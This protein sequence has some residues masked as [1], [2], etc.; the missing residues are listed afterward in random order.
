MR[1]MSG[2][3]ALPARGVTLIELVVV[4]ALVGI[5]GALIVTFVQPIRSYIDVGR[6][7]A[8]ADAADGALRRIG[9]DVRLALPNSVR[10]DA[11]GQFVELLL[12]RTGGRYR[13]G[14]DAGATS[15][16]PDG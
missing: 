1:R 7:A 9:R 14:E 5:L 2:C 16:C 10:V 13:V 6:R 3:R 15:T 4:I 11:S 12:V 8:L